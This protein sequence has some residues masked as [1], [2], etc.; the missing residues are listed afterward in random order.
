[1]ANIGVCDCP[2]G[3]QKLAGVQDIE[4]ISFIVTE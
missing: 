2:A 4:P 3:N 1:M